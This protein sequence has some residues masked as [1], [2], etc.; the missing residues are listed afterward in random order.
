MLD[1]K[2]FK[3]DIENKNIKYNFAIL[4]YS[5]TDFLGFQYVDA[6]A[7]ILNKPVK[8]IDDLSEMSKNT[9]SLFGDND[10]D[11]IYL[12]LVDKFDYNNLDIIGKDL[13]II[14]KTIDKKS[15]EVFNNY[16]VE[17]PKLE[18]WQI[19]D[20]V[21]SVAEGANE[22]S[23]D[24]LIDVC[25]N[26]IYRINQELNKIKIFTKQE[27]NFTFDKFIEDGIFSD[28][29][30]Y[31]IFDFSNAIVKRDRET[32]RKIYKEIDVQKQRL[33]RAKLAYVDGAFTLDDYKVKAKN[34]EDTIKSLEE[35]ISNADKFEAFNYSAKD[36]L[37]SRDVAFLNSKIHPEEYQ[38]RIKTWNKRTREE[39]ATLVMNYVDTIE[40]E[41]V[42][43]ECFVKNINFRESIAKPCNELYD[44]GYIDRPTPAIFGNVVGELRFSNYIP[45]EEVE[46]I[47]PVF[48]ACTQ[49]RADAYGIPGKKS[50]DHHL[51]MTPQ[52]HY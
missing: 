20:Y 10:S 49:C 31:S 44:K 15:L 35:K 37:V 26:D 50:E 43:T 11:C 5:D 23:L 19:K 34:I 25:G 46:E 24:R 33:E 45:E 12:F 32:L 3:N 17:L 36:I 2:D 29:S 22:K 40:L 38:E 28:L 16:I 18:D 51:G 8:I 39:K 42:G 1:I 52:S 30:T 21:Y 4:K 41:L 7:K 47:I 13:Y 27:R 14:C 48:R 9:F 6:I